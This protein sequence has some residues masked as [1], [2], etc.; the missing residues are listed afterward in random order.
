MDGGSCW[1]TLSS[2]VVLVIRALATRVPTARTAR[3]ATLHVARR[4]ASHVPVR[5]RGP[6]H[7]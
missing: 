6:E 7:G 3:H 2:G 4:A 1:T 5:G